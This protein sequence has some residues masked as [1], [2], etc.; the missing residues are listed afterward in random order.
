MIQPD[1]R[2]FQRLAKQGNLIPVY[3]VF[4]ADLL[5]PVSAYLRIAG[6]TVRG[7]EGKLH[8]RVVAPRPH[9]LAPAGA[10]RTKAKIM[11]AKKTSMPA[12]KTYAPSDETKFQSLN[13][14]G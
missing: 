12:A 14:S 5:T 4:S 7:G 13:A 3:D 6:N 9:G 10:L 2:E 1:F 11:L 8:S